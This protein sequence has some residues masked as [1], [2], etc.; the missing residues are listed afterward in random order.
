MIRVNEAMVVLEGHCPIEEAET[1]LEAVQSGGAQGIDVSACRSMHT[2]ILQI[3]LAAR[4][5][6]HGRVE[7]A[8]WQEFL[9]DPAARTSP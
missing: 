6:L 7:D 1:L 9:E 4:L 2:A 8:Y 5:P 3:L